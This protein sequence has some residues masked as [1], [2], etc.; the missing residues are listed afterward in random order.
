MFAGAL[1]HRPDVQPA[2]HQSVAHCAAKRQDELISAN[3]GTDNA[4]SM[5]A[6]S[7]FGHIKH[8]RA[9]AAVLDIVVDAQCDAGKQNETYNVVGLLTAAARQVTS[10]LNTTASKL[11]TNDGETLDLTPGD[12]PAAAEA[13]AAAAD[14]AAADNACC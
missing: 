2:L 14:K 10:M 6:D 5:A 9:S 13:K 1:L 11:G 8:A 7:L 12:L 4:L 3:R